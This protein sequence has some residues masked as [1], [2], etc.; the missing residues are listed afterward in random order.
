[1]TNEYITHNHSDDELD[2]RGFLKCIAWDGTGML[3]MASG[4]LVASRLLKT[5]VAQTGQTRGRFHLCANQRG[6]Q[7]VDL[8]HRF[9]QSAASGGLVASRLLKTGV[10]DSHIGFNKEA[11][12]D[13]IAPDFVLHTGDLSHL[14][15]PEEFDT[16][17]QVLKECHAGRVF[18]VPGED[19]VLNDSGKQYLA[20][21]GRGTKG[22]GWFSFDHKGTHFGG[23]NNV[24]QIREGGLGVLG[25]EQLASLGEDLGAVSDSTPLVVFAHVP[26]WEVYPQWGWGTEDGARALGLMK[27]F[28]SLTVLNGHIHQV[29]KKTEGNAVFHTA[30]STAF[31]QPVP[32]TAP[33]AGPMKVDAGILRH[34]LRITDVTYTE[35]KHS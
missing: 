10:A 5:G 4:G 3:W 20:R 32:G 31:S 22:N 8:H 15:E 24:L 11:N 30:M 6:R 34:V 18:Y 23:L 16:L 27:R 25:D 17:E 2:R 29:M 21:F 12:K 13:V 33:K 35:N 19:D 28:G 1:M 9:A 7:C 14:S 26:L